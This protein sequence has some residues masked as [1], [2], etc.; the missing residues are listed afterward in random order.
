MGKQ[1]V[2]KL[3]I[4]DVY[5]YGYSEPNFAYCLRE[6]ADK[7]EKMPRDTLVDMPKQILYNRTKF[8]LGSAYIGEYLN[9]EG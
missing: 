7:L 2:V 9:K 1:L 5:H 8:P 3:D 6:L 4:L